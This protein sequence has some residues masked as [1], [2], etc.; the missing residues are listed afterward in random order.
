MS[1]LMFKRKKYYIQHK[2]KSIP[3]EFFI[4]VDLF[5][6]LYMLD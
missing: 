5:I 6:R 1:P 2:Y 4:D 3:N